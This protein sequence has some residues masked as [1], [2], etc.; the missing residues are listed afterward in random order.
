LARLLE[1][2]SRLGSML[3]EAR[4]MAAESLA[5]ADARGTALSR[6]VEDE[7]AEAGASAARRQSEAAQARFRELAR[8]RDES[9]ARLDRN[10][11]GQLEALATWVSEQVLASINEP[12]RSA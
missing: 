2:E 9:L 1:V 3:D 11:A 10:G 12:G 7:L 5:E 4:R 6:A 8:D